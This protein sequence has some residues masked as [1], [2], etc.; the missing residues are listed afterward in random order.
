MPKITPPTFEQMSNLIERAERKG[1]LSNAEGERLR[2]GL[3]RRGARSH[4]SMEVTD[5]RQQNRL[6]TQSVSYW[7]RQ[8][9]GID[10]AQ[11]P[12]GTTP[13]PADQAA[14]DAISRVTALAQRWTHIPAKRQAATAVLNAI[15]NKDDDA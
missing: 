3:R 11:P 1:G 6:L 14:R 10:T 4:E 9:A 8:A 2:A 7:Q 5:L 12:A 13:A 15:T